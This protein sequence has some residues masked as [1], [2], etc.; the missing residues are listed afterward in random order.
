MGS[1]NVGS[2]VVIDGVGE[3]AGTVSD[4]DIAIRGVAPGRSG[5]IPVEVIMTRDVAMIDPRA[6]VADAGSRIIKRNVRRPPLVD[7]QGKAQGL[8]PAHRCHRR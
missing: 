5:D 3:L 2:V 8:A 1:H 7:G 6:D 4:R